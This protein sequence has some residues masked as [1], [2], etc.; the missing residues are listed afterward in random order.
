MSNHRIP[1]HT[2]GVDHAD[3]D[4]AGMV[5]HGEKGGSFTVESA[6]DNIVKQGDTAELQSWNN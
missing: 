3:G 6:L 2:D 5:R 4:L 1:V